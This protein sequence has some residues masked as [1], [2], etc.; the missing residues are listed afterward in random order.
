LL[1]NLIFNHSFIYL[2][3]ELFVKRDSCKFITSTQGFNLNGLLP[4]LDSIWSG[5]LIAVCLNLAK[6]HRACGTSFNRG[7]NRGLKAPLTQITP[8]P[9]V[10][11]IAHS[12]RPPSLAA[13]NAQSAEPS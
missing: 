9:K 4:S 1:N 12:E 13:E 5:N 7:V 10:A 6:P 8:G 11:C 2:F 3:T